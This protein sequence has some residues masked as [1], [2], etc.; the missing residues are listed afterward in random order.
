M[1]LHSQCPATVSPMKQKMEERERAMASTNDERGAKPENGK[2]RR[3]EELW[4]KGDKRMNQR[5]GS[6]KQR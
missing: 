5:H 1:S 6:L 4:G 2:N 3:G